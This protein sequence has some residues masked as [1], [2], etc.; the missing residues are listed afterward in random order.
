MTVEGLPERACRDLDV[1]GRNHVLVL[2]DTTE[3]NF[4]TPSKRIR[5]GLGTAGNNKD[6]GFFLHSSLVV[7]AETGEVLGLSEA[8]ILVRSWEKGD[9]TSRNYPQKPISE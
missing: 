1:A 5:E 4:S 7:D 2:Q 9:K 3:L 8:Q 6:P